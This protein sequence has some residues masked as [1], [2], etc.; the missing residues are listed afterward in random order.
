MVTPEP[1]TP[2]TRPGWRRN[3][4]GW[5]ID[6]RAQTCPAGILGGPTPKF[7]DARLTLLISVKFSRVL[8]S[9]GFHLRT[10][11]GSVDLLSRS[12]LGYATLPE[13][14]LSSIH[15]ASRAR[16]EKHMHEI[17]LLVQNAIHFNCC[18]ARRRLLHAAS[19][20]PWSL[21]RGCSRTGK[22]ERSPARHGPR[23]TS[24]QRS[25][26]GFGR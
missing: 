4:P 13:S 12:P 1:G 19:L 26:T 18:G 14:S 9:R 17:S 5:Q 20:M 25:G 24:L 15:L 22:L 23:K 6:Y 10:G 16:M 21:A 3:W 11:A 2:G 7:P 8:F